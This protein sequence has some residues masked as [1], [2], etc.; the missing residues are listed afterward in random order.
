MWKNFEPSLR[1]VRMSILTRISCFSLCWTLLSGIVLAEID[2]IQQGTVTDRTL[3]NESETLPDL[4]DGLDQGNLQEAFRLLQSEYIKKEAINDLNLN[5]A[6]IQGLLE[7]LDFGAM[8]LT[9][10]SL[11]ARNSP[12]QFYSSKVNEQIGYVRFGKFNREELDL[13]LIHI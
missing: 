9:K 1:V 8:L 12:Y 3:L 7:R 5:R 4:V 13:S 2:S 11:S 10:A 6:A